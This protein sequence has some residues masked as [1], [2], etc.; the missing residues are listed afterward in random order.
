[1]TV[2]RH[3]ANLLL[4]TVLAV[5]AFLLIAYGLSYKALNFIAEHFSLLMGL[6]AAVTAICLV[7]YYIFYFLKKQSLHRLILCG[8]ICLD[9][10]A[11]V[12]YGL[13]AGGILDELTSIDALR[14]YIDGFGS[15]AVLIYI[16]IQFL[17][18]VVLPVP[19]SVSVA[20]GVALFG[21]LKSA[22]YSFVGI[23][24]GSVV[25]FF[26]GRVIGYKAVCW[27]VGKDDL[28]KWLEKVRG[29][30]YLLLSVMFLLPLFPDDVLCFVAGLSSMT[31]PYF[32]VMIIITRLI[33]VFTT[34]YSLDIIPFT[35][36]WG[37]LIWIALLAAVVA[38]FVLV[39]RYSDK[40]DAFLRS[41]F[42]IGERKRGGNREKPSDEE[43]E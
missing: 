26:I 2:I 7:A 11:A 29:K 4:A 22:L 3:L 17:Q 37:I 39:Y 27:I 20:V 33:S 42:K 32:I 24:I 41:K 10:F 43:E 40:I 12:F 1:M 5:T 16:I 31:T 6:S 19:G 34:S 23:F 8:F 38:A 25:A 13:S 14:D 15:T 9:I 36:W 35:T 18:V 21:P 28:D 30:D